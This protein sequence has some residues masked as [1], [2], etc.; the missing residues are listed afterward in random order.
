M[1]LPVLKPGIRSSG[2]TCAHTANPLPHSRACCGRPWGHFLIVD[3]LENHSRG[4]MSGM[5]DVA[6]K[7]YD[8]HDALLSTWQ[9]M[10]KRN[11]DAYQV[12]Q[13]QPRL[14]TIYRVAPHEQRAVCQDHPVTPPTPCRSSCCTVL[15]RRRRTTRCRRGWGTG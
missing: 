2:T 11:I 15:G 7:S 6:V 5:A 14:S 4:L 12:S 8:Y 10:K 13:S 9:G 1:A 3:S